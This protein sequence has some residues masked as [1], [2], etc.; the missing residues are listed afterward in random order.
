ML[1]PAFFLAKDDVFVAKDEKLVDFGYDVPET[2][3]PFPT[4]DFII[5]LMKYIKFSRSSG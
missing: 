2:L 5:C 1:E 3:G 4:A